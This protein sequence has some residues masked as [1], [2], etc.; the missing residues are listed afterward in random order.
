MNLTQGF[1]PP[2]RGLLLGLLATLTISVA[3]AAPVPAAAQAPPGP[4]DPPQRLR[5]DTASDIRAERAKRKGTPTDDPDEAAEA[6]TNRGQRSAQPGKAEGRTRPPIAPGVLDKPQDRLREQLAQ[7]RKGVER[8]DGQALNREQMVA[9]R[10][11]VQARRI[12]L[13]QE[14]SKHI[15]R[16]AQLARIRELAEQKSNA[17]LLAKA[18]EL[19]EKEKQRHERKMRSLHRDNFAL[20]E[21]DPQ[22]E[23]TED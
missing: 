23:T 3:A 17:E 16:M 9:V 14:R 4:A 20:P 10:R 11:A 19:E 6:G 2:R 8:G 5:V 12:Q 18:T 22:A 21:A 1:K 7:Q 13:Q 15:K